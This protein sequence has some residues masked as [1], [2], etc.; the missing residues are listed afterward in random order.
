[1]GAMNRVRWIMAILHIGVWSAAG[2]G[3]PARAAEIAQQPP[4]LE[5]HGLRPQNLCYE[6]ARSRARDAYACDLAV[7]VAR[8]AGDRQRLVAALA[9]RALVLT[10]DGRLEPALADLEEALELAPDDAA[11]HSHRGNLLLRLGRAADALAAHDRAVELAPQ[12]AG[13][14]YNR[15][16]SLRALGDSAEAAEDVRAAR[17][18]LIEREVRGADIPAGDAALNQ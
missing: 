9:N 2:A 3:V 4:S 13:V 14:Y 11:L 17:S 6:A 12:D 8:D 5:A 18:R 16:F 7:Q 10:A 1:M 15:A